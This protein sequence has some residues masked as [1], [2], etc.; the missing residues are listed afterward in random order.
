MLQDHIHRLVQ[1][2]PKITHLIAAEPVGENAAP[3][4][5]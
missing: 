4:S 1:G 5:A 3:V 2:T